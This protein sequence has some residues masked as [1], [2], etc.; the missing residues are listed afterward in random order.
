MRSQNRYVN[1]LHWHPSNQV[2]YLF[3]DGASRD[4]MEA[5]RF[6]LLTWAIDSCSCLIWS[7]LVPGGIEQDAFVG[8]CQCQALYDAQYEAKK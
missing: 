4:E 7:G 5:F 6:T 8:T 2:S 3:L 1:S